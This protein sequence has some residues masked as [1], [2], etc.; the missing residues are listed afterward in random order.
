MR[1]SKPS[2][3]AD[4]SNADSITSMKINTKKKKSYFADGKFDYAG[5]SNRGL[6][7]EKHLYF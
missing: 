7:L 6:R 2:S 3:I 5:L 4:L 1:Y